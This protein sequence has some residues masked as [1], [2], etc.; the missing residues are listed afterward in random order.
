MNQI[1][2]ATKTLVEDDA[3]VVEFFEHAR[4]S[5]ILGLDT[6]F[7]RTKTYYPRLCLLQL[8]AFGNE[9]AC[10]DPLT[11][12]LGGLREALS[13]CAAQFVIHASGQDL[14]VLNQTLDFLP[15]RLFDTQIA[16]ALAGRGEQVSY[17]ALV[18]ALLGI[19]LGKA[20]TRT[21]WCRRPLSNAQIRYAFDDVEHLLPIR[22]ML[23]EELDRSGKM[24]WMTE[25]CNEL[26][27]QQREASDELVVA[28]F[29][30]GANVPVNRQSLLRRLLLWR[31]EQA[32]RSNRPREWIVPGNDLVNVA[33]MAPASAGQLEKCSETNGPRL[34]KYADSL[35][36]I[37][38]SEKDVLPAAPIWAGRMELSPEQRALLKKLQGRVRAVCEDLSISPAI[39][40]TRADLE[41][42]MLGKPG[43][44][45]DGWRRELLG[46]AIDDLL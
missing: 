46:G 24:E 16:A 25:A 15:P 35:L 44:L 28:R 26:L 23:A 41:A 20:E 31:E 17:A 3:A 1:N 21:D 5:E 18:N 13:S 12:E 27:A 4:A 7:M 43:R 45:D 10:I 19:E 11:V 34:R 37:V 6:E 22:D 2:P 30:G 40:G 42:L 33:R 9:S 8:A 29:K 38:D 39:V 32:R 36:A 14:E